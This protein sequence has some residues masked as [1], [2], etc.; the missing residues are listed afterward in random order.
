MQL[1]FLDDISDDG[2]Y[3]QVVSE[4]LLRLYDFDTKEANEFK[5]VIQAMISG[6]KKEVD[7]ASLAFINP[8]NCNLVLRISEM[9]EGIITTDN[10][11]FTCN[12][13]PSSYENMLM[14][15]TPFCNGA[16]GHQWLYNA[17]GP[18]DFLFSPGG[19][20]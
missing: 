18:I 16:S 7:L 8:V 3:A 2:R 11:N 5:Q 20:W 6:E 19:T 10:I 12:L 4:R 1:E 14:L 17:D 13:T 15:I 9:N